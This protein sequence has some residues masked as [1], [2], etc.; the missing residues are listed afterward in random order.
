[1]KYNN[2]SQYS[3]SDT[4]LKQH[5][6]VLVESF[7]KVE[8]YFNYKIF[9]MSEVSNDVINPIEELN[10]DS[11]RKN[12]AELNND[13]NNTSLNI[14]SDIVNVET[15]RS[16][17]LSDFVNNLKIGDFIPL[18]CGHNGVFSSSEI[19]IYSMFL[20]NSKFV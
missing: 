9:K 18:N 8:T 13:D 4:L 1:M 20:L 11:S 16:A 3:I 15:Y 6:S 17:V 19:E 14:T 10:S 12:T 5:L 7:P 2:P